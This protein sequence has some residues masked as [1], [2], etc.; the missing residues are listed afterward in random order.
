MALAEADALTSAPRR[1]GYWGGVLYRVRHDPVAMLCAAI[2]ALLI[3]SA[4]FA[5]WLPL[6][7]SLIHI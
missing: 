2:L 6:Q 1:R 7:L 5:P 3:L 4:I